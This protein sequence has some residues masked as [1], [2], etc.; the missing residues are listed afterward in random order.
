MS[1]GFLGLDGLG[2]KKMSLAETFWFA[3]VKAGGKSMLQHS[4][5]LSLNH[6]QPKAQTAVASVKANAARRLQAASCGECGT[7]LGMAVR[8]GFAPDPVFLSK[9]ADELRWCEVLEKTH[10]SMM[11]LTD[12]FLNSTWTM[13]FS[14]IYKVLKLQNKRGLFSN[15]C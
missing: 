13:S 5:L 3:A 14:N 15:K 7:R 10:G 1:L 11:A 6:A 2:T 9:K 8:G 4:A 12:Q